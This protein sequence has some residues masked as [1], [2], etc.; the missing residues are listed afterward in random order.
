MIMQKYEHLADDVL[1]VMT[2]SDSDRINILFSDRW[3]GY[4]KAVTI[5]DTL[6]DLLNRPR[7]L[8]PECLL[9]VGVSS[10]GYTSI[11]F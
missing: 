8:R 6:T 9:I 5:L 7:K 11:F 4:K 10:M 1:E 2:L 3:I